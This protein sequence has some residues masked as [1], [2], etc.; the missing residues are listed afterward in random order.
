MNLRQFLSESLQSMRISDAII[1][2][3]CSFPDVS[4]AEIM[5]VVH[6]LVN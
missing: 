3:E 2:A 1:A 5:S 6:E 4:R